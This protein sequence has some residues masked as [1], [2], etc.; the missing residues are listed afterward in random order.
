MF[1]VNRNEIDPTLMN[2]SDEMIFEELKL[3]LE[4]INIKTYMVCV[5]GRTNSFM[6]KDIERDING[7]ILKTKQIPCMFFFMKNGSTLDKKYIPSIIEKWK[8]LLM[9]HIYDVDEYADDHMDITEINGEDYIVEQYVRNFK[10]DIIDFLNSR[11]VKPNYVYCSSMPSYNIIYSRKAD[12][13]KASKEFDFIT[14]CIKEH[15]KELVSE[16]FDIS[17]DKLT[18][19]FWNPFMQGY[20]GYFLSRED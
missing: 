10:I 2:Q 6:A 16:D 8:E 13:E 3:Y 4:S 14:M 18:V 19:N 20:N 9:Y 12:Y 15:V 17:T 7:Q 1:V 11:D 5:V